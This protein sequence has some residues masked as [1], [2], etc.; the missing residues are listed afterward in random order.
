MYSGQD[1]AFLLHLI[2]CNHIPMERK[3]IFIRSRIQLH[4]V[5]VSVAGDDVH[6]L[7]VFGCQI[8]NVLCC[9]WR[10]M[11]SHNHSHGEVRT[12]VILVK[13]TNR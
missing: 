6:Q 3:L 2:M 5:Q 10:I 11:F 4:V 12:A 13:V 1:F 7:C 9:A 8:I